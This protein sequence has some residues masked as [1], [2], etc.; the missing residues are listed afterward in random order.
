MVLHFQVGCPVSAD[1]SLSGDIDHNCVGLSL[2]SS[3]ED[4][5][6]LKLGVSE[7]VLAYRVS[8]SESE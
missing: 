8:V 5:V 2:E 7:D 6:L 4:E 1:E 3:V